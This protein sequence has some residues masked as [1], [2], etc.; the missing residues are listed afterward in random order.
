[1]VFKNPEGKSVPFLF[2]STLVVASEGL[3]LSIAKAGR[4][5]LYPEKQQDPLLYWGGRRPEFW[6]QLKGFKVKHIASATVM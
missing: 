2:F 5:S 4:S 3:S 6:L 1:M